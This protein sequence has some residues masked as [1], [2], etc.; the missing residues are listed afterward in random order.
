[1][2]PLKPHYHLYIQVPGMELGLYAVNESREELERM[3]RENADFSERFNAGYAKW[4]I[5]KFNP[6]D[7]VA[8]SE[9]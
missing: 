1:M 6:G 8:S 4:W 9:Q 3:T 2:P 5:R 7:I